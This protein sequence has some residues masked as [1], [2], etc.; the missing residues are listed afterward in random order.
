M[1]DKPD[2]NTRN[3]RNRTY[4]FEI[5]ERSARSTG[6]QTRFLLGTGKAVDKTPRRSSIPEVSFRAEN[7]SNSDENRI[8][9]Q[10]NLD[11]IPLPTEQNTSE[12]S[13]QNNRLDQI[14]LIINQDELL[15]DNLTPELP[16]L[17]ESSGSTTHSHSNHEQSNQGQ[18]STQSNDLDTQPP[19]QQSHITENNDSEQDSPILE[20]QPIGIPNRITND[21]L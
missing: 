6:R 9:D 12:G 16:E 8:S 21:Q 2:I 19:N 3:L 13:N 11:N 18:S 7:T 1:S 15:L 5:E 17:P 20:I 10:Q 4:S 14:Q